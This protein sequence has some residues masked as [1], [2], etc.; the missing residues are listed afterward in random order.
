M[1]MNDLGLCIFESVGKIVNEWFSLVHSLSSGEPVPSG[2]K[3]FLFPS[4]WEQL[5]FLIHWGNMLHYNVFI[6]SRS[7]RRVTILL[8]FS[9][10]FKL[11]IKFI[12]TKYKL[13]SWRFNLHRRRK[14][15]LWNIITTTMKSTLWKNET[16]QSNV[17]RWARSQMSLMTQIYD[18]FS[19]RVPVVCIQ[20]STKKWNKKKVCGCGWRNIPH[21]QNKT[22]LDLFSVHFHHVWSH[23]NMPERLRC[24]F[25]VRFLLL[26]L[27]PLPRHMT[28]RTRPVS[29]LAA[30]IHWLIPFDR[31]CVNRVDVLCET[32]LKQFCI[33]NFINHLFSLLFIVSWIR[34]WYKYWLFL[35]LLNLNAL[36]RCLKLILLSTW[37]SCWIT[38]GG[39]WCSYEFGH[40]RA[41]AT[42]TDRRP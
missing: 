12:W 34:S 16:C 23:G 32:C 39:C 6:A 42:N 37:R 20:K 24:H 17:Y 31:C 7:V 29:G 18:C 22:L 10:P 33:C 36:K 9:Q 28:G 35:M 5:C 14:N 25:L 13:F 1:I 3:P 11:Q 41:A 8:S 4:L 2:Q 21:Y 15:P 38:V 27:F 26:E 19:S 40:W 30:F